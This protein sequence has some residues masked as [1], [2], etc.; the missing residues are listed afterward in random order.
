MQQKTTWMHYLLT[1][2]SV[3]T[4]LLISSCEGE[5]EYRMTVDLEFINSTDS[6]ISFDIYEDISSSNQSEVTLVP[7]SKSPTFSYEYSGVSEFVTP[8]NCCNSFL[9]NVYSNEEFGG[10]SKVIVLNDTLCVTHFNEKSTLIENYNVEVISERH[11]KY[12]YSFVAS[13]F[14]NAENC[15]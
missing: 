2:I 5:T 12:T 7:K 4:L 15:E 8:E 13:D 14:S 9:I 11:F 3:L 1:G 10:S 6:T